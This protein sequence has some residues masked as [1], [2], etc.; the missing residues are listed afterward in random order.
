MD[1][2]AKKAGLTTSH[3]VMRSL[4]HYWRVNLTVLLAAAV[5]VAV[6]TGSLLVGASMR[7]SL[8]QRALARLGGVEHAM[9]TE[10]FFREALGKEMN[11]A[12]AILLP[13]SLTHAA[14]GARANKV[15]AFG[16]NESFW[17]LGD[18]TPSETKNTSAPQQST[19]DSDA[20]TLNAALARHLGAKVGDEA[21]LRVQKPSAVPRETFIGERDDTL[22]TLRLRVARI[23]PPESIGDFT[24][25]GSQLEPLNAFVP[26]AT[27]Q[28]RLAQPA[29][30]NAL[31]L[32]ARWDTQEDLEHL[33]TLEDAGIKLKPNS[34]QGYV[35]VESAQIFIPPYVAN[36]TTASAAELKA[37]ARPTLTYL[38]NTFRH[39]AGSTPYSMIAALD[40]LG[41]K[42]GEIALDDWLAE[43]LGAKV[44]DRIDL[45]YYLPAAGHLTET[46]ATLTVAK[47][48]PLAGEWADRGLTPDF[49][50]VKEASRLSQW[51]P[52]FPLDMKRIR[53][54]DE[55]FWNKYKATPKAFVSLE[56]GRRLWRNPYGEATAIR[57]YGVS[58]T[59]LRDAMRRRFEPAAAGLIQ[60][61]V[62]AQALAASQG[63]S[64]F[65][66]LFIG[67]SLFLLVSAAMLIRIL[68][69]L[70]VQA[71]AREYGLLGA[72]G[73]AARRIRNMMLAEGA[74]VAAGGAALGALLGIGYA[75]VMIHGLRTWWVGAVGTPF[76][77]L[78]LD[79][80]SLIGGA[81]G[82][83]L[84]ALFAVWAAARRLA[85]QPARA[86]LAGRSAEEDFG[87]SPGRVALGL[88]LLCGAAGLGM[89]AAAPARPA[90]EQA[91]LFFGAGALLL[92]A[93]LALFRVWLRRPPRR[94]QAQGLTVAR[95]GVLAARRR[96]GRSMLV[97]ALMASATFLIV[98][99]GA[100]R[101]SARPT[102]EKRSGAGGFTLLAESTLPLYKPLD[103]AALGGAPAYALRLRPGDDASCLNLYKAARPRILGAPEGF[104]RRGG[105]V[106]A[107][108]L[109]RDEATRANPWLLLERPLPD[110]ATP[111]IGD[112]NSVMW[113]LH[114][115][116]GK[117]IVVDGRR[118]RFVGLLQGSVFQSEL[119]VSEGNFKKLFP[120]EA[121]WRLFAI[122]APPEKMQTV[123]AAL[124]SKYGDYGLDATGTAERL[125]ELLSV[126]NTY[127]ATFQALGGLGLLLGTLGMALA[128]ARNLIE[129]RAE[130]ALLR[131]VGW[132][133]SR[134]VWLAT[135]ENLLLLLVGM[136]AG[137]ACA[138][139][140]VAP[141]AASRAAQT[142]WGG[143]A[144]TVAGVAVFGVA[145]TV[146]SAAGALRAP[147]V[148]TMKAE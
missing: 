47:I 74:L 70:G 22:V 106:F 78:H 138:L 13:G 93:A 8:R 82:G 34:A 39:G 71:R 97:A 56:T 141:A 30:A 123:A 5:G 142:P 65:G 28:R 42:A 16:V 122:E 83:W 14:T 103:P 130:L 116:L 64:D 144:L 18:S 118:L 101:Q 29:G 81:L 67:F 72:T 111:V 24:L 20:I 133:F 33:A 73:L 75:A 50:G 80:A 92:I 105:F 59:A 95:L 100:N 107:S 6:L 55:D 89:A 3:L 129:R 119:I 88:G 62:R 112:Y 148:R 104:I 127:L 7:G 38:I 32:G 63:A 19:T 87:R 77:R 11:G 40:D 114:S 60:R 37:Q 117:E 4:G 113:L 57:V 1:D 146:L 91:P 85:R 58:E 96:P 54:K 131:A 36:L 76:L 115:G 132:S 21:L 51:K 134:L 125:N 61:P 68:F 90:Q 98:A 136:A 45:G 53:R 44:G 10:T 9:V 86:L 108:S 52:P 43:D 94:S 110:G 27:L 66:G 126:E 25:G 17:K 26:L 128:L 120:T 140:A 41:L 46:T 48:V 15:Q 23:A 135:A 145:A 35:A 12:P 49:P 84:L 147:L 69:Q 143:L 102:T 139:V 99:V 124:E 109:A 79:A 31:L 121:G 137:A 2:H